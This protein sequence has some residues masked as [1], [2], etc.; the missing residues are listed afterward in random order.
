[1]LENLRRRCHGLRRQ[2]RPEDGERPSGS[3]QSICLDRSSR[4]GIDVAKADGADLIPRN[5]G[6]A[7]Q[8]GTDVDDP[9]AAGTS[10][11]VVDDGPL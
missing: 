8:T 11:V 4:R 10:D 9:I 7:S 2:R 1:M 3:V 5:S 6:D